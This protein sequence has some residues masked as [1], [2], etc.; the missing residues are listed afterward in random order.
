MGDEA[1]EGFASAAQADAAPQP[2]PA[3]RR[4]GKDE[5]LRRVAQIVM[6]L[7]AMVEMRAGKEP[8]AA[9][10]ALAAEARERLVRLCEEVR[11]KDL[12]SSEAV[13]V[14]VEDLGL[15]RSRGPAQALRPP[16]MSICERVQHTKKKMEESRDHTA[17]GHSSL[18]YS[19]S[20]SASSEI[21]GSQKLI[22]GKSNPTVLTA[23]SF[24]NNSAVH[25]PALCSSITSM[26]QTLTSESHTALAK[27]SFGKDTSS[28]STSSVEAVNQRLDARINGPTYFTIIRPNAAANYL[29]EKTPASGIST[30]AALATQSQASILQGNHEVKAIQASHQMKRTRD[31]KVPVVQATQ[32]NMGMGNQPSQNLKFVPVPSFISNH[33]EIAKTVMGVVRTKVPDCPNLPLPSTEYMTKPLNCQVCKTIIT[34]VE[35]LLVCDGCEY[36]FHLKCLQIH[37]NR[38][39]P[40]VDWHCPKCL[41]ENNGK[42]F[43]PKYGRV[44]RSFP[45]VLTTSSGDG[46]SLVEKNGETPEAKLNHL[47]SMK[48]ENLSSSSAVQASSLDEKRPGEGMDSGTSINQLEETSGLATVTPEAQIG[49]SNDL[50]AGKLPETE[51]EKHASDSQSMNFDKLPEEMS[52]TASEMQRS[53]S[54]PIPDTKERPEYLCSNHKLETVVEIACQSQLTSNL[55]AIEEANSAISAKSTD[56]LMP[57]TSTAITDDLKDISKSSEGFTNQVLEVSQE[58]EHRS[59]MTCGQI[60]GNVSDSG[61]S[62]FVEDLHKFEWVGDILEIVD[63]RTYYKSCCIN[64]YIIKLQDNVVVSSNKQN[65]YP[66]KLLSL[67]EDDKVWSK[68]AIVNE[69][70]LPSNLPEGVGQPLPTPVKDEVYASDRRKT[71][72]A[73]SIHGLCD[74][75]PEDKF[76]EETDRR[77]LLAEKDDVLHPVFMCKWIFDESKGIFRTSDQFL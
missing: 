62:S 44:T 72:L 27:S 55:Q 64:G 23:G 14:I 11:P 42:P 54:E 13:R 36:G 43:P 6:V 29:M 51:T 57:K 7:S 75:L 49:I 39:I 21:H 3:K 8:T 38:T 17:S 60:L 76:R 9:E 1:R 26:K 28:I 69:Y 58:G 4:R 48:N 16:K 65:F 35:S 19:A 74:V 32:I 34:D 68:L 15:N 18:P 73:T 50:T 46:T 12:F 67:W 24:S 10:R 52:L 5:E 56:D 41:S 31:T 71:I 77:I 25:I 20:L 30:S 66:A 2:P 53:I 40:K 22:A 61:N 59:E 37:G 63:N 47:K 33:N 70:C 45:S